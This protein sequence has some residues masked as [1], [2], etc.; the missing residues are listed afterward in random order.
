MQIIWNSE[1]RQSSLMK[2]QTNKWYHVIVTLSPN[3]MKVFLNLKEQ[4]TTEPSNN[5]N[6]YISKDSFQLKIGQYP[7]IKLDQ[8]QSFKS[9]L[10]DL[11]NLVIWNRYLTDKERKTIHF[12]EL[13]KQYLFNVLLNYRF[14][15]L[16]FRI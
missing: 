1:K 16:F 2:I 7:D 12:A 13:G 3:K 4:T 14:R 8:L 11:D 15:T 5:N 9:S 6:N 10:M